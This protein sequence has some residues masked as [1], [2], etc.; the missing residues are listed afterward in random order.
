MNSKERVSAAL[1]R[2]PVDKV[3]LGLYIVDHDI[4]SKVIG[5]PTYVRN[6]PAMQV[7][8][9]EGRRDEIVESMKEDIIDFYKKIDCVDILT[10]KE[11]RQMPPRGYKAEN[12]PEKIDEFTYKDKN[13]IWRLEPEY[14]DIM[15]FPDKQESELK[16]YSVEQ[17]SDRSVKNHQEPSCFELCDSLIENFGK[18]YYIAGDCG[19]ITALTLLG[20]TENGLM[21]MALQP[22]VIKACNEQQVY[23]QNLNDQYYIRKGVDGVQFGQDMAGTNGPLVSPEMF[24]ELCFPYLKMRIENIKRYVPHVILHNCG[25]NL[26]I[27]NMLVAAGIDGYE[28]IQTNCEMSIKKIAELYGDQLCIWG[29]VSLEILI[30]GSPADVKR[31]VQR[32]FEDAAG[33]EGF[34][35]GPSHSIAFG[36]KYE[37]FMAMLD[38]YVRLCDRKR[39]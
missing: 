34:I 23:F 29:A 22:E 4:I 7:A 10:F 30:S 15:F 28:S 35:L 18:E 32:C 1:K 9:W 24:N 37:N 36:T 31:E 25:N 6:K 12:P 14:N 27:M 16:E 38:E 21:T 26:P 20:G 11:A 2:E 39:F 33:A 3:P 13:G 17:F 5:R 8:L 19:G